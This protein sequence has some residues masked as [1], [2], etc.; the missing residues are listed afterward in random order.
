MFLHI[1]RSQSW[2]FFGR[3]TYQLI[4]SLEATPDQIAAIYAHRLDRLE[5]FHDSR[6]DTLIKES[7]AALDRAQAVG[8]ITTTV[9]EAGTI[10]LE[11]GR[12][13]IFAY[14]AARAFR[15]SVGDLIRPGGVTITHHSLSEI[16]AVERAITESLRPIIATVAAATSFEAATEIIIEP[17][18]HNSGTP[19]PAW[20][21]V[22][23]R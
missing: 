5:C 6:R 2:S 16:V 1:A 20:P 14:R 9:E 22:W 10:W 7:E 18:P 8:W 3:R 15:I 21:K 11:T 17:E 23:R 19:P 13:V 4:A 12:S